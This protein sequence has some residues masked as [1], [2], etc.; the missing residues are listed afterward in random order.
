CPNGP[1]TKPA[2]APADD[3]MATRRV[4]NRPTAEPPNRLISEFQV[5]QIVIA[6]RDILER[7]RRLVV[8]D[9][10]ML[11]AR[12]I[13]LRKDSLPVDLPLPH[14]HHLVFGRAGR[15]FHVHQRYPAGPAGEIGQRVL[16][17]LGDPVE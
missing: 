12:L 9:E 8:L 4:T 14:D 7:L 13:L 5:L 2:T 17:G 15:V 11:D 10:E 1:R 6:R 3:A 16:T